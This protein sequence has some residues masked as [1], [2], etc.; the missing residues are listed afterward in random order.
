MAPSRV[1]LI[2]VLAAAG[3]L[4]GPL[5]GSGP[6]VWAQAADEASVA[7]RFVGMWRLVSWSARSAD[8]TTRPGITD[9]GYLVYA[10]VGRM[11]AVMADSKRAVWGSDTPKTVPDAMA[12]FA[13]FVSYCARVEVHA[14]EGYVLHH[15]DI[16]RNPDIVGRVRKRWFAFDGPNRLT[17]KIDR[18]ELTGNVVESTLVWERVER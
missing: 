14:R 18:A 12:R 7:Q 15:V 1:W 17:L 16:E 4:L 9:Q 10:D 2:A 5:A 11:C 3:W 6:F 8:G 13:G